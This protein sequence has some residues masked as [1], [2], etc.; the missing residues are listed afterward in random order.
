MR[1]GQNADA[2]EKK[3][4]TIRQV[5]ELAGVSVATVSR[6]LAGSD[7]VSAER[8][9]RVNQAV[10]ALNYTP[11]QIARSFRTKKTRFVGLVISDIEN[12][13]FTSVVRGVEKALREANYSLLLTNS[14]EDAQIEWEHLQHLHAQGVAGI[15]LSPTASDS[16]KYAAYLERGVNMVALDRMPGNIK[17]DRV[18]VNNADGVYAAVQHLAEQGHRQIAFIAGLPNASTASER[19]AG[20]ERAMRDFGFST[21][22]EWI[23]QGNFRREGGFQA[24]KALLQ[25]TSRPSAVISANNLMTLGALQAI[26]EC[27]ARVPSD[28]AVVGYDDMAWAS[29]LNPPLTVIAQPTQELG[30]VAA[31]LLLDRIRDPKLPFRHIMLDTHLIVRAS[32]GIGA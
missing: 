15:I 27:G 32:S 5:A 20:Y 14:D 7:L 2:Q 10:Q 16:K 1:K 21:Q 30:R 6:A 31:Q 23:R 18:T 12:P 13:F 3:A 11:N 17:M 22:P 28:I 8:L 24:M 26:Y 9:E 25:M 29:S 4:A 19:L